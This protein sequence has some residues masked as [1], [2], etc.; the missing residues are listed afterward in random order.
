[1]PVSAVRCCEIWQP[2]GPSCLIREALAS[3]Y[4]HQPHSLSISPPVRAAR[5]LFGP[6][7]LRA[8]FLRYSSLTDAISQCGRCGELIKEPP[9]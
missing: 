4:G 5:L 1:M 2:I 3:A 7:S 6:L 9:I 8:A